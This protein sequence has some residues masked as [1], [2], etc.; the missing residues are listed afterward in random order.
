MKC[1]TDYAITL[2]GLET[3]AQIIVSDNRKSEFICVTH[4]TSELAKVASRMSR[5]FIPDSEVF[6]GMTYHDTVDVPRL[7]YKFLNNF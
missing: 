2:S 3:P 6:C 1:S 4:S 5:V 7:L